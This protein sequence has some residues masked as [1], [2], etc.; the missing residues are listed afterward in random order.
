MVDHGRDFLEEPLVGTV[1]EVE[2]V[3][4]GVGPNGVATEITPSL[5]NDR[6][7]TGLSNGSRDDLGKP[8]GIIKNDTSKANINR[9][10]AVFEPVVE[11]CWRCI[12]PSLLEEEPTNIC[13]IVSQ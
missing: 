1:S 2:D 10:G 6:P 7:Y 8:L 11:L 3:P 5:G 4:L 13:R 12:I 9:N